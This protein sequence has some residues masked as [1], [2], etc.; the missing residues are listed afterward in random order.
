MI[1]SA[2]LLFGYLALLVAA[3]ASSY[4]AMYDRLFGA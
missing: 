4:G 3:T 2:V 1:V